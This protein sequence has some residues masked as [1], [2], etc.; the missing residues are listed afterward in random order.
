MSTGAA[1]IL[2]I[3]SLV[4]LSIGTVSLAFGAQKGYIGIRYLTGTH[5]DTTPAPESPDSV[6]SGHTAVTGTVSPGPNETV[7]APL[8]GTDAV[9]YRLRIEQ[10]VDSGS[11]MTVAEYDE[12]VPFSL[13]GSVD[14]LLVEPSETSPT[15][16]VTRTDTVGPDDSLP[17][18]VRTRFEESERI[19]LTASPDVLAS[20]SDEHRRYR[21]AVLEPDETAYVYGNCVE[22]TDDS[23]AHTGRARIDGADSSTF[24]FG[25]QRAI[26]EATDHALSG[27][28]M[29]VALFVQ[30]GVAVLFGLFFLGAGAFVLSDAIEF[31]TA[32]I[33]TWGWVVP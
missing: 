6:S 18:D 28:V 2:T 7:T 27:P 26:E 5:P 12:S 4:P 29:T 24:R 1:V 20:R 15:I 11:W 21:E 17:A 16:E 8:S 9:A 19:D 30:G 14:R 13:E 25:T 3:A 22:T 10:R 23:A 33:W 32:W 31:A